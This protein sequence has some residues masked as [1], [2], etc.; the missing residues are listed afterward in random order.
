VAWEAMAKANS[1]FSPARTPDR[2]TNSASM[3]TGASER[4]S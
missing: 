1:R 4:G 3:A 2:S